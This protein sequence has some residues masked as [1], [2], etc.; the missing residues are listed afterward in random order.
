[1][2]PC[3]ADNIQEIEKNFKRF[4]EPALIEYEG[5]FPCCRKSINPDIDEDGKSIADRDDEEREAEA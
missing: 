3:N 1:M 4:I 2:I 5:W